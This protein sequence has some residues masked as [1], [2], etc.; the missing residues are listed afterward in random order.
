MATYDAVSSLPLSIDG[1]TLEALSEDVSS[2][3]TRRTT[4]VH[5]HGGGHEGVGEDVTYGGDEQLALQAAG[6]VHEL[7]GDHTIGSFSELVD[8]LELFPDG[9]PKAPAWRLYRRWAF[10]SAALDLALRQGGRSLADVLGRDPA[11]VRFVVSKRLPEPPSADGLRRL[12]TL[13]P[14]TRFKLDPTGD[15][16]DE[17][18][19]ELV[20]LDAVDALDLKAAYKGTAVDV[21]TD[22][23]LYRRVAE[24]FPA[25]TIEDPDLDDADAAAV[26]EPHRDRISWDAVIHSVSDVESLPFQPSTL[27]IKPSRFGSLQALLDAYDYADAKGI[28]LYGGGQFELG[29]GRGQIQYLASLFHPDGPNDVAPRGYNEPEPGPGLA[30]SPLPPPPLEAGFRWP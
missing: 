7:A 30:T 25:A 22:P 8:S 12:L 27:N 29:P 10:E 18:V 3:F 15:W 17:I 11:P 16:S 20:A 1:F 4:V 6:P 24:A 19:A 5:L 28:A 2:G 13:Y 14:G 23:A 26:L 21:A 9:A